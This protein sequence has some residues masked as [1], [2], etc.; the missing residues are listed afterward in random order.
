M[1]A[2]PS[3]QCTSG[4]LSTTWF[5]SLPGTKAGGFRDAAASSHFS[6]KNSHETRVVQFSR[7]PSTLAARGRAVKVSQ[8]LEH[9]V[10]S[11]GADPGPAGFDWE[12]LKPTNDTN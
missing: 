2:L 5:V 10:I 4:Q 3:G 6:Q 8:E 9:P 1:T 7:N 11:R 12:E